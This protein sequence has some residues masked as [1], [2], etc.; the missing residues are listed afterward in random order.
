MKTLKK[1]K[2]QEIIDQIVCEDP[3]CGLENVDKAI[4]DLIEYL[5]QNEIDVI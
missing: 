4:E 3:Y 5:K 2:L 1:E